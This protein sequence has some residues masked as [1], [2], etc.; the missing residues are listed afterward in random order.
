MYDASGDGW[1]VHMLYGTSQILKYLG[2]QACLSGP[3]RQFSLTICIFELTRALL[4]TQK[5]FLSDPEWQILMEQL[6]VDDC[7]HGWHPKEALFDIIISCLS[8]GV[9][10][11]EFVVE[12]VRACIGVLR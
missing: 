8:L 3:A 4:S 2:S 7:V 1:I 12:R 9:R 5:T 10:G 6:W 11:L